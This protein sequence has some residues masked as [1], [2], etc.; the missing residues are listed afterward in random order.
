MSDPASRAT[1]RE[2][3]QLLMELHGTGLE[4]MIE[5]VFHAGDRGQHIIDE[6][7]RTPLVGSL[8]ILYGLH[9]EDLPTRVTRAVERI[10]PT[11]RKQGSDVEL[12]AI[13]E[14]IVRVRIE[15]GGHACGSTVKNLRS[16]VE[17][18]IYEAAPDITSLVV[19]GLEEQPAS[20]F[21]ALD[22]LIGGHLPSTPDRMSAPR[23]EG[24]D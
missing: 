5:I 9:P 23:M 16:T 4:K 6:F 22:K 12:L 14:G 10:Q 19:E 13:D 11:L 18:A 24:A 8:L 20:G 15:A 3:V 7:A 1:S 21:V 17:E 2:L